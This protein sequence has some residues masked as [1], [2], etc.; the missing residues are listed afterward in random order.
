M[1]AE[2]ISIG[3]EL[4]IGQVVNTNAAWMA[5]QLNLA[6]IRVRK[7]TVT[8]D[9]HIEI[10]DALRESM[11]RSDVVL[12]T[13]GLGP[14]RDDI[15]RDALC[16]FFQSSLVFNQ[17]VYDDIEELFRI[18]GYKV[19]ELNRM[20]AEVPSNCT[21]VR[22]KDG[23][24]P[25]MWFEQGGHICVSM[26]GVPF[27]MKAMMTEY[28][29]PELLKRNN[30]QFIV[31]KTVLTQGIGESALAAIIEN[32]ENHLPG[33]IKLA[34]LPQPGMVRLRLSAWGTDQLLLAEQVSVQTKELTSLIPDL[35]YG[36]DDDTLQEITGK[37]LREKN[38]SLS[39]AESC[40]G[41]YI[42]HLITSVPGSSDYFRG[43]VVA[44]ANE[45]KTGFLKV[46]EEIIRQHGAV[47]MQVV[48]KMAEG[49][50][51][52]LCTDYAVATSGI[53]GPGGA[54]ELKPVGLT[55]IAVAGPGRTVSE[56]FLFGENRERNI[57]KAA[58]TALNMLRKEL[59][60]SAG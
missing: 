37:Q 7:I 15:T 51:K 27:E 38:L 29:I 59:L 11:G 30:G 48:E 35:I 52:I 26:P 42:A 49:A 36:F 25:G 32:W 28:I 56:H 54:T 14:T 50:R 23:T 3:D 22:N 34:Y 18:R 5:S 46:E 31:H 33:N 20:Q 17:E 24:A 4:L 44:Y 47:S 40:T 8:G 12:M 1:Y 57:Q 10:I 43:S 19:S 58:I 60:T 6:G 21:P 41:G 53:A 55:W 45:V 16:E 2:I 9:Q 39:T 13:G